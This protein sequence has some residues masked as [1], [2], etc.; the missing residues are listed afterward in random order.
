MINWDNTC[1]R[2]LI[3]WCI[4]IKDFV[5]LFLE[6]IDCTGTCEIQFFSSL[7]CIDQNVLK[8]C[9]NSKEKKKQQ[10]F[11]W[12][13]W[14]SHWKKFTWIAICHPYFLLFRYGLFDWPM[15]VVSFENTVA[16]ADYLQAR[17]WFHI[18]LEAIALVQLF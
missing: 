3:H 16:S 1:K 14:C 2:F 15:C 13:N 12:K 6:N 4:H 5:I 18:F 11:S 8:N 9:K 7:M 10:Y 17:I